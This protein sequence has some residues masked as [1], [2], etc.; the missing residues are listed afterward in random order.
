MKSWVVKGGWLQ[1]SLCKQGKRLGQSI[2]RLVLLAFVGPCP[3]GM[4]CCHNDGN[5]K[6]NRLDNLRWDTSKANAADRK[7]HGVDN[8]GLTYNFGVTNYNA[9]LNDRKVRRVRKLWQ[10][11][12]YGVRQLGRMFGVGHTQILNVINNVTWRHVV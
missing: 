8:T 4:E 9:K 1:V 10:T 3:E 6:N 2:H 12:R 7:R 5:G 11:G